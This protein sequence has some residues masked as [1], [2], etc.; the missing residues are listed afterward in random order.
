MTPCFM[1]LLG[2]CGQPFLLMATLCILSA[3]GFIAESHTESH[4]LIGEVAVA[5][6]M[7]RELLLVLPMLLQV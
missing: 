2:G 3:P 5:S 7:L 1:R 6:M 4:D